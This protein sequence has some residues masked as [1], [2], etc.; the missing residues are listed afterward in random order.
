[1]KARS[2]PP[3]T[4]SRVTEPKAERF[5]MRLTTPQATL[6]RQAARAREQTMT[7]FALAVL[8]REAEEVLVEQ[9]RIKFGPEAWDQFIAALEGPVEPVPALVALMKDPDLQD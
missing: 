6:I 5:A 2:A 9:R 8:L 3:A 4:A 7:D 1:M